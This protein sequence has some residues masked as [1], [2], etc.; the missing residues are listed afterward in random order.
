MSSD[1]KQII[2][3]SYDLGIDGD[4]ESLYYWLDSHEA[5]ECGDN[6]AA[7]YF[8]KQEDILLEIKDSIEKSV[9]M[10]DKDRIYIVYKK[11]DGKYAGKFIFG[12]RKSAPWDGYAGK[13]DDPDIEL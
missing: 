10:R 9:N 11:N 3:L 13:V 6:I 5:K 7:F 8:K 4:Y 1:T 2:W 12:K